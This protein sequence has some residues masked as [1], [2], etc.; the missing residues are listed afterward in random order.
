MCY[1]C[2]SMIEDMTTSSG[3]SSTADA[4]LLCSSALSSSPHHCHSH[5]ITPPSLEFVPSSY[6]HHAATS[7]SWLRGHHSV[8]L[9][10]FHVGLLSCAHKDATASSSST[11][12]CCHV[13]TIVVDAVAEEVAA[14][15][16]DFV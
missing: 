8:A 2:E 15:G 6:E 4:P 10:F 7:L 9:L 1:P 5:S 16:E 3:A 11:Y 12:C 13:S 14:A